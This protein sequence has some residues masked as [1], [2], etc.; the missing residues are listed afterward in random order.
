MVLFDESVGT[1]RWARRERDI[2]FANRIWS[3]PPNPSAGEAGRCFLLKNNRK[4]R[5]E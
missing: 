1:E 5:G 3:C 4:K 2:Y